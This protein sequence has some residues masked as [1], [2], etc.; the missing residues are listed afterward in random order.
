MADRNDITEKVVLGGVNPIEGKVFDVPSH[1]G[2]NEKVVRPA[3]ADE[4]A[5]AKNA[6]DKGEDPSNLEIN[7]AG[8]PSYTGSQEKDSDDE[9]AIIITGADAALHL[10]PMRDDGEPALT[11]RS[12]FLATCLSAFQAGMFQI[13][14][15]SFFRLRGL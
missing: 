12:I 15:V 8:P 4:K 9:G 11:F 10:L 7:P 5:A 1:E 3:T 13:Y 6:V 14:E 2:I